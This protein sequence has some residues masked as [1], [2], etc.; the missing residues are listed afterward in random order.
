MKINVISEN[1]DQLSTLKHFFKSL[2][3]FDFIFNN[4]N[5]YKAN[6]EKNSTLL[7]I[8][9]KKDNQ[10]TLIYYHEKILKNNN[11]NVIFFLP[12][13]LKNELCFKNYNTIY[14]PL[15]I[16][17][18]TTK[19]ESS[20]EMNKINYKYLSLTNQNLLVNRKNNMKVYLTGSEA[21]ILKLFFH[22]K[23]VNK[24]IIK[25]NVLKIKPSIESKS[26]E[27]HLN[28]IRVGFVWHCSIFSGATGVGTFFQKK[29]IH[30]LFP[31]LIHPFQI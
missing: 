1:C 26:L 22:H 29:N 25:L 28:I 6:S 23:L 7:I 30:I 8:C 27:T 16:Q 31:K 17:E 4:I 13:L 21:E 24:N 5:E 9:S 19:L 2:K 20:L 10:K 3:N 12:L 14:Y 18:F 11:F 15:N